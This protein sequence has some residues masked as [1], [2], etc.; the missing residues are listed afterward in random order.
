M[1]YR[2]DV[3]KL[4]FGSVV[5]EHDGQRSKTRG[6]EDGEKM[7]QF[8]LKKVE[9]KLRSNGSNEFTFQFEI[10]PTPKA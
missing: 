8:V 10:K 9:E 1:E 4:D 3:K 5:T 7:V 2:F 6:M